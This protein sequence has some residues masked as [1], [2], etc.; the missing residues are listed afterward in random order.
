MNDNWKTGLYSCTS[1]VQQCTDAA[2]C[3]FCELSR[4]R[5]AIIGESN[6]YHFPT[7]LAAPLLFSCMYYVF[8]RRVLG[9]YHIEEE[10]VL[11]FCTIVWCGACSMCQVH[12]ELVWRSVPPGCTMPCVSDDRA[13]YPTLMR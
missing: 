1:D 2:L 12:R 11:S 7:L 6:T 10:P 8:R 4:Q 5:M 3:C 13:L 9:K